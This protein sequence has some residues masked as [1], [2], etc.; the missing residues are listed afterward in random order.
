M[1]RQLSQLFSARRLQTIQDELQDLRLKMQETRWTKRIPAVNANKGEIYG[2][3][4]GTTSIA[5]IVAV[6]AE[7]PTFRVGRISTVATTTT[8]IKHGAHFTED[9]LDEMLNME[10]AWVPQGSTVGPVDTVLINAERDLLTGIEWRKEALAMAMI[11]DDSYSY[12]NL[13]I[14]F[15]A[16]WG[17]PS[18]LKVTT[19]VPWTDTVNADPVTDILSI[20]QIAA[21]RY[22]LDLSRATMP[23]QAFRQMIQCAKFQAYAKE[24]IPPQLTISVVNIQDL[25]RWKGLAEMTLGVTI[26]FADERYDYKTEDGL[27]QS[28]R[29]QPIGTVILTDPA[30]D[31]NNMAWDFAKAPVVEA[32]LMGLMPNSSVV[33][34][35]PGARRGPISYATMEPGMNPPGMTVWAVENT[36]PRA[37]KRAIA[38]TL[39]VGTLTDEISIAQ[40]YPA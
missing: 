40:A 23:I 1:P 13:G 37:K 9:D 5:P 27:T 16:G 31:G 21:R 2:E 26:E 35:I 11:L 24:F 22:G 14:K 19:S 20:K 34:A 10:A 4:F 30:N 18:D 38:A 25:G 15:S 29:F 3:Y 32:S 17:R 36:F 33:G 7:A 28:A 8:K 12:D 6:N 39:K